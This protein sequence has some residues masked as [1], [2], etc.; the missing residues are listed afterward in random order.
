MCGRYTLRKPPEEVSLDNETAYPVVPPEDGYTFNTRFNIAPTQSALILRLQ[1]SRLHQSRLKWGLVPSWSKTSPASP[2]INARCE[3]AATKP[4]FRQAYQKRRCLV[5]A[6]GFY[7]WKNAPSG[8]QPYFFHLRDEPIFFMAGLWETWQNDEAERIDSF[9]ILTT[10]AN[11]LLAAFHDRMPVILPGKRIQ[12]WLDGP[13]PPEDSSLFLPF[14]ARLMGCRPA[15]PA[16]NSN[17]S[18]GPVCLAPPSEQQLD[19]EL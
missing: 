18:E 6:D 12:D 3:T 17:R 10:K 9:T 16:V 19:L 15:N 1:G 13:P 2:L 4:S 11:D 14:D 8:K 5:P 7:E